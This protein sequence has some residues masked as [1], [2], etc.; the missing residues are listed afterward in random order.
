MYRTL[1]N[2]VLLTTGLVSTMQIQADTQ[3]NGL[4]SILVHPNSDRD[5]RAIELPN[6]LRAL[7]I[8]DPDTDKAAASLD[9]KVGSGNDPLA[10]QGM[11]HFLEHMLFLGTEPFPE[12]GEYQAYL[13]ANGGRSN[14]YTT[15]D[16]T[17][18]Y[19]EVDGSKLEGHWIVLPPSLVL[20]CLRPTW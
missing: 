12:A 1:F 20:L 14:A 19:F 11:A 7:L 6:G 9:V 5:Y 18:Y 4:N 2:A 10:R 3:D 15:Y 17:N 8:H 16:H 13:S